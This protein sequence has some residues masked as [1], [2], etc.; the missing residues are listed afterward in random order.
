MAQA[1]SPGGARLRV[2]ARYFQPSDL[3]A[4]IR[5]SALT[6]QSTESPTDIRRPQ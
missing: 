6:P 2:E 3:V 4:V 5:A 1:I